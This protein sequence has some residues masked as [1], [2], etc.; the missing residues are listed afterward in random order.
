MTDPLNLVDEIGRQDRDLGGIGAHIR[1]EDV[2]LIAAALRL[3]EADTAL[4]DH[5]DAKPLHPKVGEMTKWSDERDVL[6]GR[7]RDAEDAY[8]AARDGEHA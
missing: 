8:R 4:I 1:H 7:H 5:E 3:A 6:I 2:R